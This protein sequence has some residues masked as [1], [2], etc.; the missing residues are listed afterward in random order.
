MKY[1]L[2]S[3][4]LLLAASVPAYGQSISGTSL[5]PMPANVQMLPH[6]APSSPGIIE[7]SGTYSDFFPSI[8]LTFDKAVAKGNAWNAQ[9]P[10]TVVEAARENRAAVKPRATAMFE[11]DAHGKAVLVKK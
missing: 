10:K 11:Q 6:Y 4:L 9:P 8:F 2:G 7:L 3:A 5:S 1:V